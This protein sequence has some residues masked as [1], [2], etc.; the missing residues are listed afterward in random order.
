M[1]HIMYN[2][3]IYGKRIYIFN[4]E[5]NLKLI[6]TREIS[7]ED[8]ISQLE[9]NNEIDIINNTIKYPDQSIFVVEIDD[10]AYAVPFIKDENYYYLKTIYP[11]RKLTKKYLTKK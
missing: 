10:Y 6:S 2:I 9:K 11:S 4:V 5:K 7:F 3:N 1:M 8:I